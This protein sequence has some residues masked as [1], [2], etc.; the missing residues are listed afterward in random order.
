[1]E[2]QDLPLGKT[3]ALV[4]LSGGQDSTTCL[5]WAKERFDEVYAITFDYGQRHHVEIEAAVTVAKLLGTYG[6]VLVPLGDG[7]LQG[8]SPLVS[9]NELEQ[10]EDHQSLPGGIENTF[11]PMRNQLFLTI[12]A[13]QAFILGCTDLVTG[14]CEE[15][16]GGYPDCRR[17]F[18]D[19]VEQACNA[20][21]FTGEAGV[22]PA[23]TIHT[24]LMH[25]TKAESVSLACSI[26]G[27]YQ[28][29]AYS[30]TAYD[31]QYPPLGHDH[32]NL[33]RAKGFEEAG[34][35]DPLVLRACAEDLMSLPGTENYQPILV[36]K[37]C[38]MLGYNDEES[39]L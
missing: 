2:Q 25:M 34:V 11:V 1:M 29:L 16:S 33:L 27:C 20:G 30:H 14:V 13:N 6:H 24:P 39:L 23:L 38:G 28:A 31:G 5:A 19:A 3:K 35:P 9:D 17:S 15:D 36:K 21:T 18:I 26:P 10:Y 32:A 8:T 7:V 22:L 4:V 12:A 37:Y